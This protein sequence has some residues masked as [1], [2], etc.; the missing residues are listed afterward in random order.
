MYSVVCSEPLRPKL[1]GGFVG[2]LLAGLIAFTMGACT[3]HTLKDLSPRPESLSCS[4]TVRMQ[5]SFTKHGH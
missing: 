3:P 4:M 5:E 1:F 2:K